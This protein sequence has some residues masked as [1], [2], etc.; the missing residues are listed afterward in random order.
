MSL[1]WKLIASIL[2]ATF[3]LFSI[4]IIGCFMFDLLCVILNPDRNFR[5]LLA[6]Y[7][8]ALLVILLCFFVVN[9]T[10]MFIWFVHGKNAFGR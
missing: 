6:L 9:L 4:G 5:T 8:N 7:E 2:K 10:S 3:M 1:N